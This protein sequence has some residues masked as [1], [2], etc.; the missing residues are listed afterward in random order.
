MTL[1]TR[2]SYDIWTSMKN[3]TRLNIL[4]AISDASGHDL[5]TFIATDRDHNDIL[6]T[7]HRVYYDR[8]GKLVKTDL[9]RRKNG[10][11]VLTTFGNVV[12]QLQLRFGKA[13][14]DHFILKVF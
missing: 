13:V 11:Y 6:K 3:I 12:Y 5:F 2:L 14:N 8:L 10:K 9:I 7:S 1:S 4:D